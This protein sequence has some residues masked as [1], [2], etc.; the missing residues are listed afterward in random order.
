MDLISLLADALDIEPRLKMLPMQA[1]DVYATFADIEKAQNKLGYSPETALKTGI[2]SFVEWYRSKAA[3][4]RN[5]NGI[6]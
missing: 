1:G 5:Q 6:L 2:L 4:S 3:F